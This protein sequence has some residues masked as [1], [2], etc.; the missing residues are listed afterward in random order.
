MMLTR[1][2]L[3]P[4][5]CPSICSARGTARVVGSSFDSNEDDT[6]MCRSMSM[7]HA[8]QSSGAA[9]QPTRLNPLAHSPPHY[10]VH[11]ITTSS[12]PSLAY[13]FTHPITLTPQLTSSLPH[14]PSHSLTAVYATHARTALRCNVN[15]LSIY[16]CFWQSVGGAPS[17]SIQLS[18]G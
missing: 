8:Q 10:L 3:C 7:T 5:M 18:I 6:R 2:A 15:R 13:S 12:T 17:H 4:S 16:Q 14:P 11:P 9:M 1:S